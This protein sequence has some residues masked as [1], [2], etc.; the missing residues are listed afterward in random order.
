MNI[1][2]QKKFILYGLAFII[3][4]II[5]LINYKLVHIFPFGDKTILYRDLKGQYVSYFSALRNAVL[6]HGGILYSFHKGLGGNMIGL[7]AYYLMS[8]FNILIILF[9][10]KYLVD[11]ILLITVLKI[12]TCGITFLYF[13]KYRFKQFNYSLL[14][15]TTAYSL[16]AFNI[17]YQ[18]NIMWLD[19]VYL[20]PLVMIGIYKIV[21]EGKKRL[22][23][24]TLALTIITSFY[25]GFMVCIFSVIYYLYLV[26]LKMYE[27]K[28]EIKFF[29][30][31]SG[32]FILCSIISGLLSLFIIVPTLFN[33]QGGKSQF[34]FFTTPL[35]KDFKFTDLFSKIYI[36]NIH[37]KNIL[38]GLP[39][40]YVGILILFFVIL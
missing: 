23:V 37:D 22:Y 15:F 25:T 27:E 36:N 18:S 34:A 3:P 29:I 31:K 12:G 20:L 21:E 19:A 13:L 11:A 8:P 2:K 35:A 10:G 24:I 6:H 1:T 30:K 40:I 28:L 16:M 38:W 9:P 5:L 17:V 26:L 33:L 32:I 4:I 39:D 14:I 7:I